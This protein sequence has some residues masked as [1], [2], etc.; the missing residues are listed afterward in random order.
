[1]YRSTGTTLAGVPR[2]QD[3]IVAGLKRDGWQKATPLPADINVIAQSAG[4]GDMVRLVPARAGMGQM[5]V[6]TTSSALDV[7]PY[8]QT[9]TIGQG[10]K[11]AAFS[12]PANSGADFTCI[13]DGNWGVIPGMNM[14]V[15]KAL[16]KDGSDAPLANVTGYIDDPLF[17]P[18]E[19]PPPPP[20]D[21]LYQWAYPDPEEPAPAP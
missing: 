19:E 17:A 2:I 3:G 16:L 8:S 9:E 1:M 18:G 20:P 6:N 4:P 15:P 14:V 12:I 11:G 10:A 7:V 13:R 5:V 21:H